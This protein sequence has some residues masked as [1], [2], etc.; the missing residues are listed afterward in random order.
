MVEKTTAGQQVKRPK[1]ATYSKIDINLQEPVQK[2]QHQYKI[3]FLR[4]CNYKIK[5]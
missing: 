2:Y 4:G 5:L 1:K 3:D